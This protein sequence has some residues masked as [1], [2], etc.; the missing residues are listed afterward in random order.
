MNDNDFLPFKITEGINNSVP[1]VAVSDTFPN[2]TFEVW[3]KEN[4]DE[5]KEKNFEKSVDSFKPIW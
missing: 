4:W 1:F 3:T 2:A 5:M